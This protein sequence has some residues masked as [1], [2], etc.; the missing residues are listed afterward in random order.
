MR[1]IHCDI[2]VI[3]T[4]LI[5]LCCG[6]ALRKL[7]LKVEIIAIDDLEPTWLAPWVQLPGRPKRIDWSQILPRAKDGV[8]LAPLQLSN[9]KVRISLEPGERRALGGWLRECQASGQDPK[10]FKYFEKK[11]PP[12]PSR[13][14][15]SLSTPSSSPF[16]RLIRSKRGGGLSWPRLDQ[17]RASLEISHYPARALL[18]LAGISESSTLPTFVE[19]D[20]ESFLFGH[21]NVP[22][23]T[24][25]WPAIQ[26]DIK[27]AHHCQ[28]LADLRLK[29]GLGTLNHIEIQ[30]HLRLKAQTYLFNL[31]NEQFA[32]LTGE[33]PRQSTSTE[34]S[35]LWEFK[36][37]QSQARCPH[38]GRMLHFGSDDL[39]LCYLDWS[40]GAGEISVQLLTHEHASFDD[41]S[42]FAQDIF[43]QPPTGQFR[44]RSSRLPTLSQLEEMPVATR[45]RNALYAG[46]ALGPRY[47]LAAQ[48]DVA[49]EL[50]KAVSLYREAP[51]NLSTLPYVKD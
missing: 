47:H 1:D 24:T 9:E 51:L 45:F 14:S 25:F 28:S 5:G 40:S 29:S 49:E 17:G 18:S 32:A 21:T 22:S 8:A 41:V 23:A 20:L 30:N 7:G 50:L 10:L 46:Q 2:A 15:P 16:A 3:G 36:I 35:T 6:Y 43:G 26:T 31:P 13:Q 37:K 4:D 27:E 11:S 19:D 48:C 34:I 39:T 12:P 42:T 44:S 38:S 33:R